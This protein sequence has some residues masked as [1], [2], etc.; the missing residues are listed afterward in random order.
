MK[1]NR[2]LENLVSETRT[3]DGAGVSLSCV[4][5]HNLQRRLDLFLL[6]DHFHSDQPEDYIADFPDH[7]HHGFETITYMLVGRMRHR[8]R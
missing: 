6:L 3:Q 1:F 2:Q 8:D 4:F 5:T 7:L